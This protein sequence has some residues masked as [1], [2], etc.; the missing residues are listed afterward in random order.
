MA[1]MI[2]SAN[3]MVRKRWSSLLADKY[4]LLQAA[5]FSEL[6]TLLKEVKGKGILLLHRPMV[7]MKTMVDIR[8]QIP[9][10][11]IFLLSDRPNVEE[12]LSFLKL[13]VV[14]Y[15]N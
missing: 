1:V 5:S 12:G 8:R 10:C 14:G 6:Q 9:Q 3:K 11:R 2:C 15:A 7:D 13:G 4:E